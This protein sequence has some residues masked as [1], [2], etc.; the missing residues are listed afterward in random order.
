[1]M[2]IDILDPGVA[3]GHYFN[4]ST[5]KRMFQTVYNAQTGIWRVTVETF[6]MLYV[7]RNEVLG[8]ASM[9]NDTS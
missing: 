3:K 2:M 7:L 9:F 5:Q 4:V 8:L 1:M 6:A